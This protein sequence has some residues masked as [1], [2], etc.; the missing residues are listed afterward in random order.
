MTLSEVYTE[1]LTR[2]GEGYDAYLDRATEMFWKAVSVILNSGEFQQEEIRK[3]YQRKSVSL[4]KD[5]FVNNQYNLNTWLGLTDS[6]PLYSSLVFDSKVVLAPVEPEQTRF[7]EVRMDSLRAKDP[8]NYLNELTGIPEVIWALNFPDVVLSPS[9][10]DFTCVL[11]LSTHSIG[12]TAK[13]NNTTDTDEYF[14]YGFLV[15]AIEMA[16]QLLKTETE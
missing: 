2:A 11:T 4:S 6:N 1:I 12:N 10:G 13:D 15:R 16:V 8:L 5:S 9:T 7:T 14:N 3:L